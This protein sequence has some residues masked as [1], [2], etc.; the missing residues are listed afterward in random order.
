MPEDKKL[1]CQIVT[2][3][4][5][6]LDRAVDFVAVPLYD[7]E[8]GVLPGRAPVVGRLGYGELRARTDGSIARYYIDGG[9]LQIRDNVVSVLTARAIPAEKIDAAAAQAELEAAS[10]QVATTPEAAQGREVSLRRA[11]A[12]LQI[13]ERAGRRPAGGSLP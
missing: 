11:R 4:T 6:V 5:I 3:E 12:Q 10:R 2:P 1:L 7:G 13:A 8:L 9:F